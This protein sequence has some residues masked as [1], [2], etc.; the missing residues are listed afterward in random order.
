M[1]ID[2]LSCFL[3]VAEYGSF[4][5][6]ADKL[7][8]SH[9]AVSKAIMSLEDNLGAQL[10]IRSNRSVTLTPAGQ[11]LQ[12]RGAHLM[13]LFQDLEERVRMMG[14]SAYGILSIYVP[15]L[16]S[17][18]LMPVYRMMK[19]HFPF[20]DLD[21]RP[22]EPMAIGSAV[23]NR[24]VDAGITFSFAVPEYDKNIGFIRLEEDCFYAVVPKGHPFEQRESVL[25]R[26]V[27]DQ[28]LVCPPVIDSDDENDVLSRIIRP[29]RETDCQ[30]SNLEE[31][32]FQ[33]AMGKGVAIMPGAA[34]HGI[35]SSSGCCLVP[36]SDVRE[37]LYMTVI[38]N[39]SKVTPELR[40]FIDLVSEHLGGKGE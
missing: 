10:L 18:D 21:I 17:S 19:T 37:P 30:A 3:M 26:D 24:H 12:D 32:I 5:K 14:K 40:C 33:V 7:F 2:Q 15:Y 23:A 9:S 4:T 20:V 6:A 1:T 8:M 28:P 35:Y 38:W 36:L 31:L 29:F 25:V 34:F 39:K 13:A 11:L 16:Y 27:L 22:C